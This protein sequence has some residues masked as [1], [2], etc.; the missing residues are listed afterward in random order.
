MQ[1]QET[2]IPVTYNSKD[3]L[4]HPRGL[5]ILSFA[6]LFE[7]FSYY[8]M[9]SLLILY[10]VS[11]LKYADERAY[12]VYGLYAALAYAAPLIG[13]YLADKLIGFRRAI[14]LGSL[15]IASG[16]FCM[17][18]PF[19]EAFFYTG[20]GLIISGTGLFKSNISALVGMLYKKED[21]RRDAGFTLFYLGINAGGFL[22]PLICG[23][24]G[25]TYGWHYGFGLAGFGMILGALVLLINSHHFT[26]A[27]TT[28]FSGKKLS[29]L[30]LFGG[31]LAGPVFAGMVY[32][33]ETFSNLL[34]VIGV[35]FLIYL[36]SIA[37]KS[38][39]EERKNIMA[40]VLAICL[41]LLSGAL[42][43]QSG[44]VLTLFIER[45]VDRTFLG[46]TIPT[47]FFQSIDPLTVLLF[48]G[49]FSYIWMRLA[50]KGKDLQSSTKYAL[51]FCFIGLSYFIIYMGCVAGQAE[52]GISALCY[53]VIGMIFLSMGDI[54]IYPVTLSLCSK[55]APKNLEG[56][57]MGGV[58]M[59]VS[60]S[61][62]FGSTLAK[63]ASLPEENLESLDT[64]KSLMVYGD[65]FESMSL[66]AL[67]CIGIT[68]VSGIWMNKVTRTKQ[69]A[70]LA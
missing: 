41:L 68:L 69:K 1:L 36:F 66:I 18:L 5:F 47:A 50:R 31:L 33:N 8:G 15:V 32:A 10:M 58:M 55:L 40:L 45:N 22:A 9:R 46:W 14:I 49:V 38:K 27:E 42:V 34:P 4:G 21:Q 44:M 35:C 3:V 19:G 54:C 29:N 6:E 53:A 26:P 57:M 48:G 67:V 16:H 25:T 56:V 37:L 61:Y 64:V 59:G 17:A 23:Y 70:S 11:Q 24:I 7:R 13:G 20:L 63:F 28:R 51:G 12:G 60:F 52:G 43:E 39:A 62:L 65:L 2:E 30:T